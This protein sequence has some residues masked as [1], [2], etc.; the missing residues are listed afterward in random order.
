MSASGCDVALATI[1]VVIKASILRLHQRAGEQVVQTHLHTFGRG[2]V[3]LFHF[4]YQVLRAGGVSILE[5]GIETHHAALT[6]LLVV[7]DV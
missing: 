5:D 3:V 6:Q 2:V 7:L 4:H 1:I